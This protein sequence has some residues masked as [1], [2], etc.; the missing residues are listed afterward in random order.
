MSKIKDPKTD[1]FYMQFGWSS[2]Q[3]RQEKCKQE[4]NN[5]KPGAMPA[6]KKNGNTLY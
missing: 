3:L 6:A 5:F 4:N 2:P 1:T